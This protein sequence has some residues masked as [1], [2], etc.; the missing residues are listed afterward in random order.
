MTDVIVPFSG[1]G[2]GTWGSAASTPVLTSTLRIWTHDNFGQDL[3]VNVRNGGIYYWNK[4]LGPSS[5]AV[6]LD[7]LSGANSTPTI[8]KQ[9]LVSDRDRHIIA[10]G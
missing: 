8:A 10:F 3:L 6:S 1:W 4:T 5:R 7:S 2:R 9:V